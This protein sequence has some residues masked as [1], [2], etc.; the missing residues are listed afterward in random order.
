MDEAAFMDY[1]LDTPAMSGTVVSEDKVFPVATELQIKEWTEPPASK[2]S[3][4]NLIYKNK[5]GSNWNALFKEYQCVVDD[6]VDVDKKSEGV[7]AFRDEN[8]VLT[9][10]YK[11]ELQNQNLVMSIGECNSFNGY[12]NHYVSLKGSILSNLY[13]N[14]V[15]L[16]VFCPRL[17]DNPYMEEQCFGAVQL[18]PEMITFVM[19]DY[20]PKGDIPLFPPGALTHKEG[21]TK[22]V[23]ALIPGLTW[24]FEENGGQSMQQE[25]YMVGDVVRIDGL[26]QVVIAIVVKTAHSPNNNFWEVSESEFSNDVGL[27]LLTVPL[28]KLPKQHKT[29]E[30]SFNLKDEKFKKDYFSTLKFFK[31]NVR[32]FNIFLYRS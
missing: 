18:K 19:T 8:L 15:P 3:T 24:K 16:E 23:I 2:Y 21:E 31:L 25:G 1:T 26:T 7:P 17:L 13:P 27:Y 11:T 12:W 14:L 6:I 5:Y 20:V 10:E 9:R 29:D 22:G 28:Y 30:L 4:F 32:A